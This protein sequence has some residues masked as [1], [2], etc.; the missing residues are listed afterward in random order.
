MTHGAAGPGSIGVVAYE[1]EGAPTGVGR[2]LEELLTALRGTPRAHGWRLKLFFKGEPFAHPL[3]TGGEATGCTCE[4]VFDRRP[5][6][7]P[8][9]WEQIRLPRV[10]RARPVDLLFSPGY[11]LPGGAS[12]ASLVTI[13]D[14]SFEVLPRD[15]GF[16]ERWRRR[17]LARRAARSATRVLTDT[18]RTAAE[19]QGRYGVP[20]ERIA[21]APLGVSPRFEQAGQSVSRRNAGAGDLAGLG[22]RPPYL[23]ILGSI[24]QRRRLDLVLAGLTRLLGEPARA[25]VA[26]AAG[27]LPVE[28]LQLVVAG[29]NQLPRPDDLD[30]LI[31]SSG[32]ADRVIRVGYVDDRALP[33]L[34]A[35]AVGTIYVSEYEGYGL[36]PLESLAAGVPA[37]VSDAPALLELW[38]DYPLRCDRLDIDG[39]TDGLRRLL[40]DR[41][42]RSVASVRGPERVRSLTWTGAAERFAIEVETAWR[43][44]RETRS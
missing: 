32:C 26:T 39:V 18:G 2:Y 27:D 19:L 14:L 33:E 1:M 29:A 23:L 12:R 36:P 30:G 10:L 44:V 41:G 6:A 21:V 40:F 15:F 4:A 13:H 43:T 7:H 22:V 5:D 24:L 17:F 8:I 37:L 28:E 42:A 20:E 38:P 34:Y 31:R 16:R 3:W 9:F 11:S 35:A 25:G